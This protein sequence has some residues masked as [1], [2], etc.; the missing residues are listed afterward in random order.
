MVSCQFQSKS[1]Y[2]YVTIFLYMQEPF[3]PSQRTNDLTRGPQM[4]LKKHVIR[5]YTE[6]LFTFLK[7]WFSKRCFIHKVVL[8]FSVSPSQ[9]QTDTLSIRAFS[10]ELDIKRGCFQTP[11]YLIILI[12]YLRI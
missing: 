9:Q 11:S 5:K 3:N 8:L 1:F 7:I 4:K 2:C 10:N 12:F 6:P